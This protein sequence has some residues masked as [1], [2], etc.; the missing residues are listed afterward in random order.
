LLFP[1][2]FAEARVYSEIFMAEVGNGF[3][4]VKIKKQKNVGKNRRDKF[5]SYN[6][7]YS[8]CYQRCRIQK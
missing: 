8:R 4:Y 6:E 1:A 2:F 7:K 3:Q 5:T